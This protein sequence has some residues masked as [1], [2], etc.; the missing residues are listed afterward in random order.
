MSDNRRFSFQLHSGDRRKQRDYLRHSSN[1]TEFVG[2]LDE[3]AELAELL[4]QSHMRKL[5][6]VDIDH[7]RNLLSVI[8]VHHRMARSLDFLVSAL[9]V[10]AGTADAVDFQKVRCPSQ[11]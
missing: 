5:L 6:D 1:L 4:P 7:I 11:S 3:T 8:E 9:K 10:I 2:I